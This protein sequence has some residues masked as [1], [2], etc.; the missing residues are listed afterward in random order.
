MFATDLVLTD[1]FC[2]APFT[3][4][5]DPTKDLLAVCG[6]SPLVATVA[7][8]DPVNGE[9]IN[10]IRRSYEGKVK[11][12]GLAGRNKSVKHEEG[13]PGGL[14]ELLLWPD[15][16][17]Q[18]QKVA[19]KELEKGFPSA[20]MA[21]LEKAMKLE[22]GPVPKN[23]EWEN[24]LGHEKLKP[25]MPIP[26]QKMKQSA[27]VPTKQLKANGH[28]HGTHMTV[29]TPSAGEVARPK[30][31]GWKRRYDE[32]SFEGYGEGFVDD[33]GDVIDP[34]GYS[35]AEGSRKSSVTKKKRKKVSLATRYPLIAI[36]ARC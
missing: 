24:I 6:L 32:H 12:F 33:D 2:I 29:G 27:Q 3:N 25:G 11:T 28:V 1:G 22:P 17:W 9:K 13:T 16:E 26:E 19:G 35:S 36:Q 31:S 15:E 18:N 20:L 23:D 34:G 8:I 30:R 4:G 10:K 14:L 5:P 7:R 21:K